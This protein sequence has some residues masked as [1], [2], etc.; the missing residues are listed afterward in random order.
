[1]A[2]W[3]LLSSLL[4]R[5]SGQSAEQDRAS[6]VS[7]HLATL[8]QLW[9]L[10]LSKRPAN[11][12]DLA[13]FATTKVWLLYS[14]KHFLANFSRLAH[15]SNMTT[16]TTQ[17]LNTVLKSVTTWQ[18]TNSVPKAE[19]DATAIDAL[20]IALLQSY[21]TLATHIFNPPTSMSPRQSLSASTGESSTSSFPARSVLQMIAKQMVRPRYTV[22]QWMARNYLHLDDESLE[23]NATPGAG[24]LPASST[25]YADF[26]GCTATIHHASVLIWSEWSCSL[27]QTRQ[28]KRRAGTGAGGADSSSSQLNLAAQLQAKQTESISSYASPSSHLLTEMAS[29]FPPLFHQQLESHQ[30]QLLQYLGSCLA[31]NTSHTAPVH[32]NVLYF[33]L[34]IAKENA[35]LSG[36]H[37]LGTL[38][39]AAP[40]V[41]HNKALSKAL[42]L[43]IVAL[44][45]P[46]TASSQAMLRRLAAE[47]YSHAV[48]ADESGLLGP[49]IKQ[50][51]STLWKACGY[52]SNTPSSQIPPPTTSLAH[53]IKSEYQVEGAMFALG[54]IHRIVGGIRSRQF[55]N[56][57][58]KVLTAIVRITFETKPSASASN[59]ASPQHVALNRTALHSLWISLEATGLTDTSFASSTLSTMLDGL[60]SDVAREWQTISHLGRIVG[61]VAAIL[62]PELQA[63]LPLLRRLQGA[64]ILLDCVG[65]IEVDDASVSFNASSAANSLGS[66]WVPPRTLAPVCLAYTASTVLR[67]RLLLF[68]PQFID[69]RKSSAKLLHYVRSLRRNTDF[70]DGSRDAAL[71]SPASFMRLNALRVLRFLA[72]L[73]PQAFQNDQIVHQIVLCPDR[74]TLDSAVQTEMQVLIATLE[75]TLVPLNP[76]KWLEYASHF[77]MGSDSTIQLALAPSSLF[78]PPSSSSSSSSPPSIST[79]TSTA[80]SSAPQSTNKTASPSSGASS[81]ANNASKSIPKSSLGSIGTRFGNDSDEEEGEPMDEAEEEMAGINALSAPVKERISAEE[82]IDRS[83]SSSLTGLFVSSLY[84]VFEPLKAQP[85]HFDMA[86]AIKKQTE[87][88]RS[89]GPKPQFLVEFLS[90]IVAIAAKASSAS[91]ANVQI[92]GLEAIHDILERFSE[93]ADLQ[94]QGHYLLELYI[95]QMS[96]A[97]RRCIARESPVA[98]RVCHAS[99]V[100]LAEILLW[101]A[102]HVSDASA[103]RQLLRPFLDAQLERRPLHSESQETLELDSPVA[104]EL[105]PRY[106]AWL[107]ASSLLWQGSG[108]LKPQIKG[109]SSSVSEAK[110]PS[111]VVYLQ[112]SFFSDPKLR[113]SLCSGW[114]SI[115]EYRAVQQYSQ[116]LTQ[117]TLFGSAINS[118]PKNDILSH[119]AS[120]GINWCHVLI[121]MCSQYS[122]HVLSVLELWR[123]EE[124]VGTE[125]SHENHESPTTAAVGGSKSPESLSQLRGELSR[126]AHILFGLILHNM[127]NGAHIGLTLKALECLMNGLSQLDKAHVSPATL[128]LLPLPVSAILELSQ[129]LA[130]LLGIVHYRDYEQKAILLRSATATIEYLGL[131]NRVLPTDSV[132]V[133]PPAVTES[134]FQGALGATA[135]HL[136]LKE[137]LFESLEHGANMNPS[138]RHTLA[139]LEAVLGMLSE[140]WTI[141]NPTPAQHAALA[142]WLTKLVRWSTPD[143]AFETV[144]QQLVPRMLEVW[145]AIAKSSPSTCAA[146]IQHAISEVSALQ[147]RGEWTGED[148]AEAKFLTGALLR[149]VAVLPTETE[150]FRDLV[151][152]CLNELVH[153]ALASHGQG[154]SCLRAFIQKEMAGGN[155]E[156]SSSALAVVLPTLY[157]SFSSNAHFSLTAL[158]KSQLDYVLELL[159]FT[160]LLLNATGVKDSPDSLRLVLAAL[161]HLLAPSSLPLGSPFLPIHESSLAVLLHLGQTHPE[162][163][164][165]AF[166]TLDPLARSRFETAVRAHVEKQQAQAQAQ[167]PGKIKFSFDTSQYAK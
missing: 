75:E 107:M 139:Y 85:A 151:S 57:T 58:I 103:L 45:E 38:L 65:N 48:D 148:V 140:S 121:A 98:N 49:T 66:D 126:S 69:A 142:L 155:T 131:H 130:N 18:S 24:T 123:G 154:L 35:K 86:L 7:A 46:Y 127:A 147:Q 135:N 149:C 22:N 137:L 108:A 6:M 159:K 102:K 119:T 5:G 8:Q 99:Y 55:M 157:T 97:L 74:E 73:N 115:L 23:V 28:S 62:G 120:L 3:I 167:T 160:V 138:P 118:G 40:N 161:I 112:D 90:G 37:Q 33:L 87:V 1:V 146:L 158:P 96:A 162:Q 27:L 52:T 71:W 122:E 61:S 36:T 89:G 4:L 109:G 144:Q 105:N 114:L 20:I 156:L 72:Q 134:F 59:P 56:E 132:S 70:D 92:A 133:P 39:A 83:L 111:G 145:E 19:R 164:K 129:A 29:L 153:G 63:S 10:E 42:L 50:F 15:E 125:E 91:V 77:V 16:F 30:Q 150:T 141:L 165:N 13:E 51:H 12:A 44:L 80:A 25:L 26:H 95:A 93:S 100:V 9:K 81:S 88:G 14:L 47:A 21:T 43:Q 41:A 152:V 124:S 110:L 79:S 60:I 128:N 106:V 11:D 104:L 116:D 17:C 163:F 94:L 64:I 117:L 76:L 82:D 2:G 34:A 113:R 143:V 53:L 78:T 32:A 68:A 136:L 67:E 31:S 166:S 84:Y 101:I 54:A